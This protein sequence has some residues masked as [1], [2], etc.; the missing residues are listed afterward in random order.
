MNHPQYYLGVDL[1]GTHLRAALVDSTDGRSLVT[2]QVATQ[3]RQG[4]EAVIERMAALIEQV[5]R[6]SAVSREQIGGIGIGVPGKLD[7]EKGLTLFL[8][9]LAGN[10]PNVPLRQKIEERLHLPTW[11][12]NDARAMTFGEWRFG[13]GREVESIA[14]FT[15]GTGIGGG[16]VVNGKLVLNLGGTAGELGHQT[17]DPNGPLCGCGNRGCLETYASGP[18]IAAM[19]IKA[20]VQGLTTRIA[21]LAENDLNRITPELIYRAACDGDPLAQEIYRQVGEYLG[22]AAANVIVAVGPQRI[23]IGGGVAQAGDLLLEPIR[24]TVQARARIASLEGVEI[25][26]AKLGTQAGL[27]G[28][29]MWAKECR[30]RSTP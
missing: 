22:V 26:L 23:V 10:W 7:L 3:A 6:S 21:E 25:V 15:L 17:I 2:Q 5:I 12:I 28:A 18:A 11:L 29:A 27:V 1:G 19:G 8:P 4:H 16:L 30:E 20:V 9:N 13:A 24:R 14:C